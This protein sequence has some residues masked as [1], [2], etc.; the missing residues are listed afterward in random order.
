[1]I[2]CKFEI[3]STYEDVNFAVNHIIEFFEA[4]SCIK[5]DSVRFMINFVLR[6]LL[7]NAVEHGNKLVREKK[8]TCFASYSD[9]EIYINISDEGKGFALDKLDNCS[10]K[11][12]LRKRRRGLFTIKDMG[13]SVDVE[14]NHVKV[15][16]NLEKMN[17]I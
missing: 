3:Y 5:N 17:K 4:N 8:V 1:M 14:K 11:N 2:T 15:K 16:L 13:L 7:I 9:N 10:K 12:T 6:E